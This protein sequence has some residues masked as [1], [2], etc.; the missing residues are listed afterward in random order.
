MKAS[1]IWLGLLGA[2]VTTL[3]TGADTTG[4]LTTCYDYGIGN[5]E[6]DP[7]N[8]KEECGMYTSPAEELTQDP[9]KLRRPTI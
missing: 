8:N 4:Y 3:P 2:A 1:N 7:R 9:S 5:G 6:C